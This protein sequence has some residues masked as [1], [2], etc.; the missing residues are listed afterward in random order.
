LK[1]AV[2]EKGELDKRLKTAMEDVVRKLRE[3]LESCNGRQQWK[4]WSSSER[5]WS[6]AG[7]WRGLMGAFKRLIIR[8][9]DVAQVVGR[10]L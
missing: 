5:G 8:A 10:L 1:D 3:R 4:M 9:G 2:L 7:G 6:P